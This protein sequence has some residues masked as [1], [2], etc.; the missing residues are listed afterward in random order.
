[1][2]KHGAINKCLI[3]WWVKFVEDYLSSGS[4]SS[5][6]GNAGSAWVFTV[7]NRTV[8][9]E[10]LGPGESLCDHQRWSRLASITLILHPLQETN[11]DDI[12]TT[13]CLIDREKIS[14]MKMCCS[15]VT[16]LMGK[17][18]QPKQHKLRSERENIAFTCHHLN[19]FLTS[20]GQ[21]TVKQVTLNPEEGHQVKTWQ[22]SIFTVSAW[23]L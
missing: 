23:D 19:I 11:E 8:P 4:N 6:G 22:V 13:P 10:R 5:D 1:M 12:K 20:E 9:G 17:K 18:K 14:F 21:Q 16:L 2:F 3:L 15:S 7:S